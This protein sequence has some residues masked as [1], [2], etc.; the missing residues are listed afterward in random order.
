MYV[1]TKKLAEM[2]GYT[3]EAI[4]M[5]VKKGIWQRNIHYYK[6]PDNKLMFVVEVVHKWIKGE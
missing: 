2:T 4:R 3:E 6:A 1:T 5:K